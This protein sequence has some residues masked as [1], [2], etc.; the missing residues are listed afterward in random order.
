MFSPC[1]NFVVNADGTEYF[2]A[3][4][5]HNDNSKPS[6]TRYH[7]GSPRRLV[8][9][10][11]FTVRI[12]L[13]AQYQKIEGQLGEKPKK[14]EGRQMHKHRHQ[15][16]QEIGRASCRERVCQYVETSVVAVSSKKKTRVRYTNREDISFNI[17]IY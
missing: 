8:N 9:I 3:K 10:C 1:S 11:G 13:I 16:A 15:G 5:I 6:R 12:E 2:L 7:H 4:L 17:I 14:Q